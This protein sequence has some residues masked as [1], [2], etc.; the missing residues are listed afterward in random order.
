MARLRKPASLLPSASPR[1]ERPLLLTVLSVGAGASLLGV[2]S[3]GLLLI[4]HELEKVRRTLEQITMGVR[5]IEKQTM[6]LEQQIQRVPGGLEAAGQALSS[7]AR[8][9][10]AVVRS[11]DAAAPALRVPEEERRA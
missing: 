1:V 6:P 10:E 8:Q 7:A 5:A 11:L 2:L 4:Q 9:M 3:G